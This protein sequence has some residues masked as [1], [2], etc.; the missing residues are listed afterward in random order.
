M[1][2]LIKTLFIASAIVLASCADDD[3]NTTPE[4]PETFGSAKI[5]FDHVWEAASTSFLLN[6]PYV[7]TSTSEDVLFTRLQYYITNIEF[8]KSDGSHFIEPESYHLLDLSSGN[9]DLIIANLPTGAYTGVTF[10][11][12]V[13]SARNNSGA[14]TGALDPANN[15]FW[16]WNSGY[17]FLKAEGNSTSS[18]SG[19]F[20]YHV[21]GF[22]GANSAIREIHHHFD[23][24]ALDVSPLSIPEVHLMVDVA[25][26]WDS[27]FTIGLVNDIHM[28]GSSAAGVAT[29]FAE[30]I[31]FDHIHN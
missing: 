29:N 11:L 8:H 23:G 13:D 10:Y 14:Q 19:N 1:K 16:S 3:D 27:E 31:A 4:Q 28:P 26:L 15:M 30:A 2:T 21:G 17:I 7:L 22:A 12:G 5:K 25:Q 24:T 20:V 6:E 18:T 9:S